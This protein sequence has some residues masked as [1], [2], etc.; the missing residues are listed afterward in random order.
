MQNDLVETIIQAATE[1]HNLLGGPGL[2]ESIYESA[3]CHELALQKIPFLRQVAVP[4]IYKGMAVRKPLFVDILIGN[5]I[6]V[7]VKALESD[8]PYYLAQLNT[9]LRLLGVSKGLL[10][11][12]G[13][14]FLK[15]GISRIGNVL[16]PGKVVL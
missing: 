12:F 8:N 3:L 15:D 10:I 13:K 7:E 14:E 6:V 4:V 1:V 16:A 5:Q 2:L 11:N 9:H